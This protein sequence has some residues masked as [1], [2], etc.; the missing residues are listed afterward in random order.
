MPQH[1]AHFYFPSRV[2]YF[3]YLALAILPMGVFFLFVHEM[4]HALVAIALGWEVLAIRIPIIPIEDGFVDVII[5]FDASV[6]ARVLLFSAGSI[7][8]FIVGLIFFVFI[9]KFKFSPFWE[10]AFAIYFLFFSLDLMIYNIIDVFFL[11]QGDWAY[12]YSICPAFNGTM[13]IIAIG[14][15][16]LLGHNYDKIAHRL[17]F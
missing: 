7:A 3:F 6:A 1:K 17:E 10:M 11:Q 14:F 12:I 13:L 15:W 9:Y 2:Q 4:G 8:T 5:P 16:A